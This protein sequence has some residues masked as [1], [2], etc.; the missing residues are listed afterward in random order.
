MKAYMIIVT[1]NGVDYLTKV[2]AE[3]ESSVEHAVLNL[4]VCGKHTYGVT[5]CMAYDTNA[6]KYDTFVYHAIG[7]NPVSFDALKEIIEKR[8]AEI[9]EKDMA[10][11]AV[12]TIEKQM[13]DLQKQL[14]EAKA[15]LAK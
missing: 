7:A 13:K 15:I 3:S 2:N 8:N 1:V 12:R 6:M 4:S 10:E 14:E 5:A 9:R 11:E